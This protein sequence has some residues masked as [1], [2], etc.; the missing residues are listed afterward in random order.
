MA[1]PKRHAGRSSAAE[2]DKPDVPPMRDAGTDAAVVAG[3]AMS[4]GSRESAS[5]P[6]GG[7][8]VDPRAT[9]PDHTGKLEP[10]AELALLKRTRISGL[11]VGVTVAAVVLL[12]LLVF[13]VQNNTYVTI[14]FFGWGGQFPLG[15]A[16]LLAAICG[17]LLVAVPGYGRILQL[18]RAARRAARS[19]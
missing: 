13:I 6:G 12:L 19:R 1:E 2:R 14:Y 11:W 10:A 18:R 8:V 9:D 4:G 17:V 7:A 3:D 16:L 15:V 5:V